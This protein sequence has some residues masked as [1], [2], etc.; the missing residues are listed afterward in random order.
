MTEARFDDLIHAPVRLSIM[1]MLV[2]AEG[3]EFRFIR[4][5]LELSDS[6]LSKHLTALQS[7]GYISIR[8][9]NIG[10]GWRRSWVDL[11]QRGLAAFR[12]HV[13]ALDAIVAGARDGT[14]PETP[15]GS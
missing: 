13:A 7:A 9:E 3:V 10:H 2:P 15:H 6:V 11:T 8:K 12:G 1:A 4:E 5:Q 14:A